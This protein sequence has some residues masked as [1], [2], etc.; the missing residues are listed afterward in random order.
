MVMTMKAIDGKLV[1]DYKGKEIT[2]TFNTDM[3]YCGSGVR[4][5]PEVRGQGKSSRYIINIVPVSSITIREF[6]LTLQNTYNPS[7]RI[8]INGYESWTDSR[9]CSMNDPIKPL[10][11]SLLSTYLAYQGD[12]TFYEY[13]EEAGAFHSFSYTYI[14]AGDGICK[15]M[16]SMSE[17]T[18]FTIFEHRTHENV[19]FIRKDCKDLYI[20]G[21]YKGIDIVLDEGY[22]QDVFDR[23]FK[24]LGLN[25]ARTQPCTGWTSWYYYYNNISEDVIMQ[26]LD[27]FSKR[28][29][30]ID[31]FQIDDGYQQVVGDWTRVNS[32]FP[33]GM[34]Y[35][36]QNIK[37]RGY[38]AGLWLAPF[39]GGI[40]SN[41]CSNHP[42]CIVCNDDGQ[43]IKIGSSTAW[44]G[45]YYAMDI[46]NDGFRNYLADTFHTIFEDWGFDL[47][48]LDFLYAACIF[49]R[50]DKTRGQIMSDAMKLLKEITGDR[51]ILGC[52]VPLASSFGLVDYCRIGCD[53]NLSWEDET[54]RSLNFRERNST[55]NS[56]VST[57]GRHHLNGHAF[58][59]DPDVFILRSTNNKLSKEQRYTLTLLNNIFGGLC[60]TSDN[61]DEYS[62]EEMYLYRSL[63]PMKLKNIHNVSI[64]GNFIEIQFSIN[65]KNY[66]ALSNFGEAGLKKEMPE[67][68][69]YSSKTENLS[70]GGYIELMPYESICFLAAGSEDYEI[71]GSEGH[72]FPGSEVDSFK[73]KDGYI[74]MVVDNKSLNP[75]HILIQAPDNAVGCSVNGKY[76]KAFKYNNL[77]ILKV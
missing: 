5:K 52:G 29:I 55:S 42:E 14:K 31:I 65:D 23:Y 25:Q 69:Y 36:T 64:D 71:I 59:N 75:G 28:N 67:G 49:S 56:L 27:A 11:N 16:A 30:P 50:K 74:D 57:I 51:L 32:K 2:L 15:F 41:M 63:F 26:N 62:D 1:Y 19:L 34:K 39:L 17:H 54:Y 7:D 73:V 68:I 20:D 24:L 58:L 61:L 3:E 37:K 18:G 38:K 8:F 47:V 60:F 40:A 22:E 6:I 76:V 21:E 12:Y 70:F 48:K 9:E 45:D 44:G 77:N 53:V 46:Y 4:I 35:I 43:P 13:T 10:D 33:H 72:I 66:I